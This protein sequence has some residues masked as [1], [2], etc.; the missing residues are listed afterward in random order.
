MVF[1]RFSQTMVDQSLWIVYETFRLVRSKWFFVV[2]VWCTIIQSSCA[3]LDG[4]RDYGRCFTNG[5]LNL[6]FCMIFFEKFKPNLQ[7]S[8]K[9]S[10][11]MWVC[12]LLP[13]LRSL[14]EKCMKF[15]NFN[16]EL[17]LKPRCTHIPKCEHV[18]TITPGPWNMT[19]HAL[20]HLAWIPQLI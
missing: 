11:G 7:G 10:F 19:M 6:S 5:T 8:M 18:I 15:G 14:E 2:T 9:T 17:F 3:L 4:K 12:T 13:N 20:D 1:R 16:W